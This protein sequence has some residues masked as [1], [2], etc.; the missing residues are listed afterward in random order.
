[1]MDKILSK[2]F[3]RFVVIGIINTIN[4]N[5]IY[6]I[7]L[8]YLPYLI[9]N[10]GAFLLSMIISFFLNSKYTFKVKMSWSKFIYFPI[11]YL[12]NF[13]SQMI[14]IIILVELLKI[15][16][17]YA[18]FLASLIAIPFTYITMKIILKDKKR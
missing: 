10:I 8:I 3:G 1:M 13:I 18:A 16:K 12:P 4:H 6:L 14:G 7:L 5:I 15:K 11:S 17:E 9:A 2:S